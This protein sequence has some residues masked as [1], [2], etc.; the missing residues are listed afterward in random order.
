[1]TA[2][3][4]TSRTTLKR[5]AKRGAYD[6]ESVHS[7]LDA[8][9]ICHVGFVADDQPFVIPTIHARV[10]DRLYFHGAMKNRMLNVMRGGAA[11]CITATI[12]DSLVLARSAFHHS[13][14]YRSVV[15]LGNAE[16]VTDLDLKVR[17]FDALVEH[18]LPGRAREARPANRK[19][20][21]ATALFS[22]AIDEASAKIRTGDPVDAD[23]DLARPCWAGIVP[24]DLRPSDPV[25]AA[26][27][28]AAVAL[29]P[30]AAAFIARGRR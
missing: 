8:A 5:L 30:A 3:L 6:R 24:L 1:M 21:R 7:I 20:T 16:E 26:D 29:S 18:V 22:V 4:Q 27:L 10:D 13:M 2:Q 23:E 28:S 17:V 15:V 25:A 12:V 9:L 14:N 11:V 19:E